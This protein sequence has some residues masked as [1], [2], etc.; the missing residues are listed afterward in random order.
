[1]MNRKTAT[2]GAIALIAIV[3]ALCIAYACQR[4]QAPEDMLRMHAA[5]LVAP[6]KV[7]S[8]PTGSVAKRT[9]WKEEKNDPF[10]IVSFT[11]PPT[12]IKALR[13][14]VPAAAER[15]EVPP[16][17]YQFFGQMV[18]VEGHTLTFLMRDGMLVPVK[19]AQVLDQTYRIDSVGDKQINVTYLPL[20][21]QSTVSVQ[22][23]AQ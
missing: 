9:P 4:Y 23:A 7:A 20:N 18:D 6:S 13:P 5:Q 17:P 11:P 1:M 10:R 14:V 19:A 21:E 2:R 8:R 15:M 22:T 16:F 3:L 12:V